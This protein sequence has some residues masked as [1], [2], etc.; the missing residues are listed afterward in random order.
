[1][2]LWSP[3]R[4]SWSVRRHPVGSLVGNKI[5]AQVIYSLFLRP[6]RSILFRLCCVKFC[7]CSSILC[8]AQRS[9]SIPGQNRRFAWCDHRFEVK[10]VNYHI[11]PISSDL[12]GPWNWSTSDDEA[13][14]CF[15]WE[16]RD[17]GI[18]FQ[19]RE[20]HIISS[21]CRESKTRKYRGGGSFNIAGFWGVYIFEDSGD[22]SH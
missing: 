4:H 16:P 22:H 19:K 20:R 21:I 15:R 12:C 7:I 1:M 9:S 13:G 11:S 6:W 17:N 8:W 3:T 18:L 2:H 10:L 14:F 5:R